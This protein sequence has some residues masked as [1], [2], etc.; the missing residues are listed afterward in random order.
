LRLRR[1]GAVSRRIAVEAAT[2]N[3]A[4]ARQLNSLSIA[5][6]SRERNQSKAG[7][8][9]MPASFISKDYGSQ[10]NCRKS[11]PIHIDRN[12]L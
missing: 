7:P 10:P 8:P 6:K 5:A 9:S 1:K 11:L 12:S 2:P 4:A 3:R